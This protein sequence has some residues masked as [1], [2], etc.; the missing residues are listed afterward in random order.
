MFKIS[1][2]NLLFVLAISMIVNV[3]AFSQQLHHEMFG[4]QGGVSSLS[5]GYNVRY[6]VGQLSTTGTSVTNQAITQQGYQQS[7]LY[8][9]QQNIQISIEMIAFPNPF[10]SYLQVDFSS[11]P[12]DLIDVVIFDLLG[13]SVFSKSFKNTSNSIKL[14]LDNLPSTE[15]LLKLDA[16]NYS[17]TI[18]IIKK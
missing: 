10:D 1:L 2:S 6:S 7:L 17:K 5:N 12:G 11:S 15:Y 9:V 18:K 3:S 8:K 16:V 4:A 13:R 14:D